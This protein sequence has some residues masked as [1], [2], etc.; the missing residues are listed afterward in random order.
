MC[1]F[2]LWVKIVKWVCVWGW[3]LKALCNRVLVSCLRVYCEC[4][5]VMYKQILSLFF[6]SALLS[7][8]M[9]GWK[10][11]QKLNFE[12]LSQIRINNR[13]GNETKGVRNLSVVSGLVFECWI[14]RSLLFLLLSF[15]LPFSFWDFLWVFFL[16]GVFAAFWVNFSRCIW[17]F[18]CWVC[19]CY[20]WLG[21][22]RGIFV[23]V[24]KAMFGLLFLWWEGNFSFLE[25]SVWE[26]LGHFCPVASLQFFF[27]L[28]ML[29]HMSYDLEYGRGLI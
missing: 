15:L 18:A 13:W 6:L 10:W 25:R 19:L 26:S 21:R 9:F 7:Y 28:L 16:L 3:N 20:V 24:V 23:G 14:M 5:W 1:Q 11:I 4:V 2:S 8:S 12:Y 17:C 29:W 27:N 22:V